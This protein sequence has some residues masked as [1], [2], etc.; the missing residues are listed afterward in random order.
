VPKGSPSA[1]TGKIRAMLLP[2]SPFSTSF[3]A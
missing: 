3:G 2:E 1:E